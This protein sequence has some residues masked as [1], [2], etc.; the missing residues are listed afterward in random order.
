VTIRSIYPV[1]YYVNRKIKNILV[2]TMLFST[3]NQYYV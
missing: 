2:D 1:N 3:Y